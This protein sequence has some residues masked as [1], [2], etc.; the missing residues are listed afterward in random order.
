VQQVCGRG[1]EETK[2]RRSSISAQLALSAQPEYTC[3]SPSL[4]FEPTFD[5]ELLSMAEVW[6]IDS[7]ALIEL[8]FSHNPKVGG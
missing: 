7:T 2:Q 5:Q 3:L 6:A 8:N 1:D 4:N